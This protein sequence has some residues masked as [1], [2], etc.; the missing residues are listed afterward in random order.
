MGNPIKLLSCARHLSTQ[1]MKESSLAI[2]LLSLG[3]LLSIAPVQGKATCAQLR[4]PQ[5]CCP[6]SS[7]PGSCTGCK[8]EKTSSTSSTC[9]SCCCCCC[10]RNYCCSRCC[11]CCSASCLTTFNGCVM[12]F[13]SSISHTLILFP[14]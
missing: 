11:H 8:E 2:L 6:S 12:Y 7:C 10:W 13:Q 9:C 5:R 14:L 1:I 3:C 4:L